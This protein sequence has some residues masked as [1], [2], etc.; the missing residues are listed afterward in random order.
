M[1]TSRN[2][3]SKQAKKRPTA[4]GDTN[5]CNNLVS[6]NTQVTQKEQLEADSPVTGAVPTSIQQQQ[7]PKT[8][9][10][11]SPSDLADTIDPPHCMGGSTKVTPT[12]M[13]AVLELTPKSVDFKA[14]VKAR[15]KLYIWPRL[16]FPTYDSTQGQLMKKYIR[17]ELNLDE[18]S[19]ENNWRVIK[20]HISE[21][22]RHQ[23]AYVAQQMKTRTYGK[24]YCSVFYQPLQTLALC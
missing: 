22:L 4:V 14:I 20:G 11:M 10:L 18:Q 6:R 5:D 13:K 2:D 21:T 24:L 9:E 15:V 17:N 16:K 3:R 7:T 23:R 12:M 1:V 8:T 19:F